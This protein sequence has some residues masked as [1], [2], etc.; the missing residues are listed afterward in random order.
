[1]TGRIRA[2]EAIAESEHLQRWHGFEDVKKSVEGWNR[3]EVGLC[4]GCGPWKWNNGW[5]T[6][7]KVRQITE[8]RRVPR[9]RA[10]KEGD[11]PQLWSLVGEYVG[12]KGDT[13]LAILRC[14]PE[15]LQG[16]EMWGRCGERS[17]GGCKRL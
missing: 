11:V 7:V 16:F 14:I 2:R 3:Q 15:Q 13:Q 10:A 12:G 8:E 9:N 1:M 4:C 17:H 6:N 5:N